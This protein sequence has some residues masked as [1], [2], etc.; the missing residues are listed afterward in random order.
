MSAKLTAD[1]ASPDTVLT[2]ADTTAV[3]VGDYIALI[4]AGAI[5]VAR[6]VTAKTST[7]I[8]VNAAIGTAL[9][10]SDVFVGALLLVAFD[11][12][13]MKV[14]WDNPQVADVRMPVTERAEEYV[15]AAD[16]T[17]GTT[18]GQL[19]TK[20][21]L[22]EFR[23][24]LQDAYMLT[25]D[26]SGDNVNMTGI[27]LGASATFCFW[28]KSSA[29]ANTVAFT[30]NGDGFAVGPNLS[31]TGGLIQLYADGLFSFGVG[32]PDSNWHFFAVVIDAS[33]G[34]ASRLYID[35]VLVGT[36]A[37]KNP[38]ATAAQ[39]RIG[40]VEAGGLGFNGSMRGASLWNE[41]K[42][43]AQIVALMASPP[44]GNEANIKGWWPL[45]EGIG[46]T[47][48]D[49]STGGHN[50]TINGNPVWAALNDSYYWRFNGYER[51]LTLSGVSYGD[52][53]IEHGDIKESIFLER[54]EVVI[55]ADLF[56]D[57][58]MVD[59]AM[60]ITNL[61]LYLKITQVD[62]S[63]GTASNPVVLV[64][65]EFARVYVRGRI[66]TGK[67]I[68]GGL[69]LDRKI[70]IFRLQ[71]TCNY[72]VYSPPC[73]LNKL[74]WKFTAKVSAYTADETRKLDLT[75]LTRLSGS[76]PTFFTEWFSNGWI[77]WRFGKDIVL[78]P[79]LT[80]TAPSGGALSVTLDRDPSPLP[81]ANERIFLYPGCDQKRVTCKAYNAGTNP[82]GKFNND[83]NFGGHDS[84]PPT[85]PVFAPPVQGVTGGKK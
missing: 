83:L 65:G 8:T 35:G 70:P 32:Y 82:L 73:T 25:M 77:G 76:A 64:N 3:K 51:S 26:G 39:I 55:K 78:M 27:T 66:I 68:P 9:S 17:L 58:P 67:L 30:I 29:Y 20:A 11:V 72:A 34:G 59:M 49:F 45:D 38:T 15:P 44:V 62:V 81:A 33:G 37:Y 84:I 2:V 52:R 54:N 40:D 1:I 74:D 4:K 61:P 21:Y 85:N 23:R 75:N 28:A 47:A 41:A 12:P 60:G 50:G 36:C 63:G 6:K 56:S 14:E 22:Y 69:A 5:A 79:I 19:P 18:L 13:R 48:Y 80:S 71:P 31:F 43:A 7:T 24:P 10:K 16:E 42:T 46:G 53:P 57:N